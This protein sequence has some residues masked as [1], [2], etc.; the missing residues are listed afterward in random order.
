MENARMVAVVALGAVFAAVGHGSFAA[1]GVAAAVSPDGRN[2]IRLYG[3]PL[4]YEVSRDGVAVAAKSEVGVSL[5][6]RRLEDGAQSPKSVT[7]RTLS[8]TVPTPVNKKAS[9][10]LAA[11][12]TL[13][14]FGDFAVRL[15][16]R[17]DGVAYRL[18]LKKA[19]TV[20]SEKAD[21]TV[22]K[23]ARCWFNR[24]PRRRLGCEE[25]V[26]EF[27]DAADLRTDANA[28]FYL[29]FAY[30]SGGKAVVV[31]ESG[32]KEYPALYFGDVEQTDAGALLA[33]LFAKYPKATIRVGGWG[34]EK[35]LKTGGRWV[36]VT[37][38]EDYIAKVD[39]S[40][41]LP[42][43]V[44]VLA[45]EPSKL[46]EADI[47]YALAE[48]VAEGSDFSWVRPGKV[49]W[50]WWNA[51]DNKGTEK[52]CTTEGYRRFIDFAAK[53]GVEYVIFDEGWSEALN[54]WKYSPRVDVPQLIEYGRKKGVGIILWMAWAQMYGQEE[55]V[56]EHFSKLGAVGFKVDFMD[57]ADA[58][59]TAFLERCAK[60]CA[61]H[62]LLVDFHG[63]YR[64]VGLRRTYPN[65]VNYEGI[66][67]L[68]QMKWG[69]VDKDMAHN[70]VAAFFLRMTVGPM[71]YT[72]GAMDN[73]PIGAYRGD[74]TNPG[75]VG[76]R[77]HQM[78]LMALYEAPLQ[79]LSDSPTKYERN[80]ECFSFM[81]RTPVVWDETVGLGG[82]PETF[83]AVARRAKDGSWYAAAIAN[84]TPRV[85]DLKT[86]FLGP[87]EWNVEMF[88]DDEQSDQHPEKYVHTTFSARKGDAVGIRMASGGGFVARFSA[89]AACGAAARPQYDVV[90]AGG[91]PAGIGAGYMAA[92]RGA[93]TLVLERGGRL[94]GMAVSAMVS[95]F[96]FA[97]DS[98]VVREIAAK[99]G[100]GDS[101]DFHMADVRAYD[102]LK[103]AG[104]DVMLH[105]DVLGPVVEGGRVTGV[106]VHC[107]EGERA[108]MAKVVID[109]TGN[110]VVAAAAGVPFEEGRKGDGLVQPMS[111]MFTVE[112]FDPAHRFLCGSEEAARSKRCMVGGK[113][114][115]AVV[116]EE[117]GAG[118]LPPEVG[119]IRLYRG[120]GKDVNVVNATQVNGL[121][122][123]LSEDLTKAEIAAR[124][125]AAQV[126]DVL[127][128]RLPGYANA[129][130]AEMPAVVGV[131]ETRRFEGVERLTVEDVLAGRRRDDAV[132][133][134]C[135]FVI[136]IHNPAGAGQADGRDKGVTGGAR[137]VKPYDI[138]YGCLVPK[139]IDGLL[140][141][142]RCLSADHE[143]LASCR[144]MGNAMATGVGAGAAAADAV[145]CGIEVRD[146]DAKG[147]RL[148]DGK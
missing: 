74:G 58:E 146:V 85:F 68:E 27:A 125:Q 32:L 91:G 83:A 3:G 62:R 87:G 96:S 31:A 1:D 121:R 23:G 59:V 53:S 9:V 124:R 136:D 139:K 7:R 78:A 46:C 98:P 90:V 108:F 95:P 11:N 41:A 63:V 118:R 79:M 89:V 113:T 12:E 4:A 65:I 103:E 112:G 20:D 38:T 128:R 50:D 81:A 21:V 28:A 45:D 115:E 42:W 55:R 137:R 15:V 143:A 97:T 127:R 26:P 10:S 134:R 14:D 92:K 54:I 8:G 138:P 122:G 36:R 117:I 71:D 110:G 39:A 18:E 106:R 47:V 86:D 16:A 56:A 69:R 17:D 2:A 22:P 66:H 129:R 84:K 72:P 88:R 5:D 141:C 82:C 77:C 49:A 130:I 147:L 44:F 126:V 76:T 111:V 75:S 64:P 131:R 73:Y 24:T 40:R 35:G 114:W 132:A 6:G 30:S 93:K 99:A 52:G 19:G 101:V 80:M 107:A 29:P 33:S 104:A 123:S 109:A 70:D 100:F 133:R 57:R 140:F 51:F 25:T 120:R 37:E 142:G 34:K 13:A 105:A 94:G 67:G 144:V 135:S 48:P 148:F 116:Q 102:L 43:R 60:A 145:R 119:V 61:K